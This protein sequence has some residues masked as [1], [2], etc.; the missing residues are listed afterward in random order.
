MA[1]Q[2]N[3]V[4]GRPVL[5]VMHQPGFRL[6]AEGFRKTAAGRPSSA[7][8]SGRYAGKGSSMTSTSLGHNSPE[9]HR[10]STGWGQFES[11]LG[12]AEI[13]K[14]LGLPSGLRPMSEATKKAREACW[15]RS[16]KLNESF[17]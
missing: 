6:G 2:H 17:K 9:L 11:L 3:K 5:A 4:P 8:V 12:K 10:S 1:W 15:E 14:P 16:L 7:H 13:E